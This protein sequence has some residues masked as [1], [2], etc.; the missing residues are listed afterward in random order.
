MRRKIYSSNPALDVGAFVPGLTNLSR[1]EVDAN[2]P[3]GR[4]LVGR[5]AEALM[6][7]SKKAEESGFEEGF[8]AGLEAGKEQAML[9]FQQTVSRHLTEFV[10][11]LDAKGSALTQAIQD[12]YLRSEQQLAELSIYVAERILCKELELSRDSVV[13]ITREA[14]QEVTH[15]TEVRIRVNPFDAESIRM[16]QE[17]LM[18]ASKQIR[19]VQ[20]VTD[21]EISGGCRIESDAGTV[22]ASLESRLG[23]SLK[24]MK[25]AA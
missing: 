7:L 8:E 19:N 22:D 3:T 20:I 9:E 18:S 16:H 23:L 11:D 15:A 21:P 12:W 4:K 25:E 6:K 24:A 2:A 1:E 10:N 13:E 5:T 14:L 17:E